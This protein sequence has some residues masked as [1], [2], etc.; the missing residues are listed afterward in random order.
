ME[1]VTELLQYYR[2]CARHVY[3]MYFRLLDP[4]DILFDQVDDALFQTLVLRQ[5]GVDATRRINVNEPFEYLHIV[6]SMVSEGIPVM[7]G[8]KET[9]LK[10]V[11]HEIRL[12]PARLHVHFLGYFDWYNNDDYRDWH[13]YQGRIVS[14]P[15]NPALEGADLIIEVPHA[16]V[17]FTDETQVARPP[18]VPTA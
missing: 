13:Y 1:D 10:E 8:R 2:E 18:Y 9:M 12:F 17:F 3:N 7:W 14:Y 6:P 15:T 11:W 5:L 16:K 4:G